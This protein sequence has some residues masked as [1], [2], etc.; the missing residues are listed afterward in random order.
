MYLRSAF[1]R[2]HVM[3]ILGEAVDAVRRKEIKR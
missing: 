3:Q 1:D 2:F